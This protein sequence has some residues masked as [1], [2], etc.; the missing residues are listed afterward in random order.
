MRWRASRLKKAIVQSPTGRHGNLR[1]RSS[2]DQLNTHKSEAVV[3][4]VARHCGIHE[5]LGVKGKKG[6]LKS[7]ATR[8]AFLEDA[9][10]RISPPKPPV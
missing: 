5:D 7:M 9:G 10:H 2:L 6:I 4:L 3:R 8:K 1:R